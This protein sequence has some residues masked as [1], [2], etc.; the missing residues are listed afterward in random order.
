MSTSSVMVDEIGPISSSSVR[1]CIVNVPSSL[2]KICRFAVL[3]LG[4]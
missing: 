3:H 1:N 2:S 4:R